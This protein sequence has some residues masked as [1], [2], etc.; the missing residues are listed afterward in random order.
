MCLYLIAAQSTQNPDPHFRPRMST[1]LRCEQPEKPHSHKHSNHIWRHEHAANTSTCILL[2]ATSKA[3]RNRKWLCF[4]IK[5]KKRAGPRA[6]LRDVWGAV[7]RLSDS[8]AAACAWAFY[9]RGSR[10]GRECR[11]C[12][13][14]MMIVMRWWRWRDPRM[15]NAR[16]PQIE[17]EMRPKEIRSKSKPHLGFRCVMLFGCVW[18]TY[19]SDHFDYTT[20]RRIYAGVKWSQF[21]SSSS[22]PNVK[23]CA[24]D[25]RKFAPNLAIIETFSFVIR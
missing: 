9:K 18:K 6:S 4:V 1:N 16:T 2:W 19:L 14:S 20:D 22:V 3:K 7:S 25:E 8:S 24:K 11:G 12:A 10:H 15:M 23:E 5:S 13:I 17:M 21:F